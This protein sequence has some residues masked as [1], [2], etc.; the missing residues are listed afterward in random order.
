[1]N[2]QPSTNLSRRFRG[3]LP[4]V[5]D[6]ETSGLNSDT[7]AL[8]EIAAVTLA[9]DQEGKLC[10]N[11]TYAYHGE[12]FFGARLEKE[13]LEITGIDPSHPFRFPNERQKKVP[14]DRHTF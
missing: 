9:I 5:V 12:P 6:V 2:R 13:S 4:I 8:L 1:M 11:Q 10:R 3:L 14:H 7:D